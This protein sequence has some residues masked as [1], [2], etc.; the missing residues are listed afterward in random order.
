ML[1]MYLLISCPVLYCSVIMS[2]S[3]IVGFIC[4]ECIIFIKKVENPHRVDK[5]LLGLSIG[6]YTLQL[7]FTC[8]VY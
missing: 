7:V 3:V 5:F 6:D 4:C 2:D 8:T 1:S